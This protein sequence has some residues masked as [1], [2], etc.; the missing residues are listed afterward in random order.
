MIKFAIRR[1]LKYPLQLLI[2][3]I[4]RD[5][6]NYLIKYLLDFNNTSFFII[7]MFFGEFLGGLIFYIKEYNF[8]SKNKKENPIQFINIGFYKSN[9]NLPKDKIAKRIFL[10]FVSSFFDLVLFLITVAISKYTNKSIT[11]EQRFRGILTI[12]TT[13]I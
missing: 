12:Y 1:N 13:Y 6:D 10:I 8:L 4:L 9:Q 11:F 5:A 7:L 3:N 2:S